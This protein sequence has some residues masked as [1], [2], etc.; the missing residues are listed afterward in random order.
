MAV[1]LQQL[2]CHKRTPKMP[3]PSKNYY[4]AKPTRFKFII[5]DIDEGDCI[6]I[7]IE[8]GDI[9]IDEGDGDSIIIE[10]GDIIIIIIIEEGDGD[11]IIIIEEGDGDSIIIIDEGYGESIIIIEEGDGDI[12]EGYTKGDWSRSAD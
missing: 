10:E 11:S 5:C 2:R 1:D 7:I 8:E 6:I 12:K 4:H 3:I 9:I